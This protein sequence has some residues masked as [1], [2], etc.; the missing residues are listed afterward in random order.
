MPLE[1]VLLAPKV[2]DIA[3]ERDFAEL[4]NPPLLARESNNGGTITFSELDETP[5]LTLARPK[6]IEV[7]NDGGRVPGPETSVPDDSRYWIEGVLSFDFER[8]LA[9]LFALEKALGGTA[10]VRGVEL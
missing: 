4:L 9:V 6:R 7:L 1:V 2:M 8:G 5:V 10:V 3:E